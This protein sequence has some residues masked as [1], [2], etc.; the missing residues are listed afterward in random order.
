MIIFVSING[1]YLYPLL[2]IPLVLPRCLV[3][4]FRRA[5]ARLHKNDTSVL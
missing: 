3:W 4:S 2:L 5:L 1:V